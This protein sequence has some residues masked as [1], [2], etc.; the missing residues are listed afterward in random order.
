M[1]DCT[2]HWHSRPGKD[3]LSDRFALIHSKTNGIPK[4]WIHLPFIKQTR[5]ITT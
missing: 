4:Y 3:K 1:H 2:I 5:R